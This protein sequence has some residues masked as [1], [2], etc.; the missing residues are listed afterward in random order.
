[1]LQ[2]LLLSN[3][4]KSQ[5]QVFCNYNNTNNLD[6][7]LYNHYINGIRHRL[8]F[9]NYI[10]ADCT[11]IPSIICVIMTEY[12]VILSQQFTEI[13]FSGSIDT[14]NLDSWLYNNYIND[15]RHWWYLLDYIVAD[16]NII[17]SIF[18]VIV[19]K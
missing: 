2:D 7:Y 1:M 14:N 19:A 13:Y 9:L 5:K 4:C 15:N 8:Y 3:H 17:S 6:I 18:C 16:W 12:L 11:I 10:I